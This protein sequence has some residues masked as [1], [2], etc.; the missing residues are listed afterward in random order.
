MMNIYGPDGTHQMILGPREK[1]GPLYSSPREDTTGFTS[2]LFSLSPS[3][4]V[5]AATTSLVED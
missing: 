3:L 5:Q 2:V 1:K 4:S